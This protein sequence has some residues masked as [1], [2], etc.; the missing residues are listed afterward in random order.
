MSDLPGNQTA[1]TRMCGDHNQILKSSIEAA[2]VLVQVKETIERIV[3]HLDRHVEAEG[4]PLLTQRVHMMELTQAQQV[5]TL[6]KIAETTSANCSTLQAMRSQ[7]DEQAAQ[8]T[9]QWDWKTKLTV[10]MVA[11][12]GP[13]VTAGVAL[14]AIL[15]ENAAIASVA[16]L[17]TKK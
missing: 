7:M 11:L 6:S 13:L 14:F 17:S 9:L 8:K 16:T 4:H 2:T 5:A 10:A 3:D 15:H 12:I 1:Q